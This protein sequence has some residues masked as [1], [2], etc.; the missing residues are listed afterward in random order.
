MIV[1]EVKGVERFMERGVVV[2]VCLAKSSNF[3][4]SESCPLDHVL[5]KSLSASGEQFQWKGW[6]RDNCRAFGERE[7]RW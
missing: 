3:T 4:M 2:N 7:T 1:S 6:G 5:C